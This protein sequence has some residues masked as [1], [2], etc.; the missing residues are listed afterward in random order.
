MTMNVK[1]IPALDDRINDIRMRTA[2]IVNDCILPNEAKLW[3]L[4]RRVTLGRLSGNRRPA[5]ARHGV[6]LNLGT[7]T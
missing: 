1:P 3:N 5:R 7:C 6:D 2:E 4:Q